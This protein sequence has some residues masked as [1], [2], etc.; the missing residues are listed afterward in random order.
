[1][2]VRVEVKTKMKVKVADRMKISI[3]A[4]ARV[5]GVKKRLMKVN[6]RGLP[7]FVTT[8]LSSSSSDM[9]YIGRRVY[10]LEDTTLLLPIL[11]PYSAHILPIH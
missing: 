10:V 9:S 3:Y 1:M 7:R 4:L 11:Y 8:I 6:K 5:R 2:S